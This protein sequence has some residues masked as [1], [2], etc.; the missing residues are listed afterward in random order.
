[1]AQNYSCAE[2]ANQTYTVQ[3]H[4]NLLVKA[5]SDAGPNFLKTLRRS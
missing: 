2:T 3:R 5:E 1:M 4:S